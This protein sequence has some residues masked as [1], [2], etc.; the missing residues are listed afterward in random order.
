[1]INE[2]FIL[3]VVGKDHPGIVSGISSVLFEYGC[4]INEL[5]QTVLSDEFA[6]ILLLQPTRNININ[7]LDESLKKQCEMLNVTHFLRSASVIATTDKQSKKDKLI[8]TVLGSDKIGIIAGVTNVLAN[9][10]INII[11]LSAKPYKIYDKT[12]YAVVARVEVEND[13]DI[14]NL[15]KTFDECANQ[16]SVDIKVQSQEIF[17]AMHKI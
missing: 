5:N 13:F 6:M 8:I 2:R 4:N 15:T 14:L 3:T 16:L 17:R 10:N 9:M 12:Q 11:D 1:M 7:E